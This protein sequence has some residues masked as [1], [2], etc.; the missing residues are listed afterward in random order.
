MA[1]ASLFARSR[2]LLN[3]KH[4]QLVHAFIV[5]HKVRS[6]S[7]EEAEWVAE[8]CRAK[9]R[10]LLNV[11]AKQAILIHI[12]WYASIRADSEVAD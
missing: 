1:L 12:S 3:P 10:S 5:D 2:D 4:T 11:T 9:C 8:Q 7:T 6:E